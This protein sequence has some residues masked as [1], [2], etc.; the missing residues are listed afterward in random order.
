MK[1]FL[2]LVLL[3]AGASGVFAI[4]PL[5][6]GS[7]H[8]ES[9]YDHMDMAVDVVVSPGGDG[10]MW[11]NAKY[12][13]PLMFS[14]RD[15]LLKLVQS[16]AKKIDIAI[17]NKSSIAF[18]QEVG[19]F[20]TDSSALITVS[21]ETHGYESSYTVVEITNDGNYVMFLLNKK[22]TQ[23]FIVVLGNAH[24]LA[25]DYQRQATLFK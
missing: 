24:S 8:A 17:A 21:F 23:D 9:G 6:V 19:K 2:I 16:V 22:D 7:S 14:E 3:V 25:D 1:R 11:L 20:S 15:K 12:S 18:V 4:G 13:Y 5:A 10:M